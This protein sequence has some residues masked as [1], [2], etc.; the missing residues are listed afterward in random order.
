MKEVFLSLT[1]F[2]LCIHGFTQSSTFKDPRDSN[3]YELVQI[4]ELNWF[5]ENLK[6]QFNNGNDTLIRESNCGVFYGVENA[7]KACPQG[8]RLPTEKEVKSLLKEEKKGRLNLVDTLN[9]VL[10][11][12]LDSDVYAKMGE[13]NTFWINAELEDGHIVHWHTFGTENSMHTHNV[14]VARRKFPVRCVSESD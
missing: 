7:L 11:G 14:T 4:G 6:Y 5:G 2:L 3:E 1:C 9:I 13:Q 10:C 12:R 8:W